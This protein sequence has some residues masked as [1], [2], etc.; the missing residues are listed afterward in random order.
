MKKTGDKTWTVNE[1]NYL[2]ENH[3]KTTAG[4]IAEKLGRSTDSVQSCARRLNLNRIHGK[5]IKE[6]HEVVQKHFASMPI[7]ELAALIGV[8]VA[9]LRLYMIDNGLLPKPPKGFRKTNWMPEH[10]KLLRDLVSRLPIETIAARLNRSYDAVRK[11][12]STLKIGTIPPRK[13]YEWKQGP[14][15]KRVSTVKKEAARPVKPEKVVKQF[16]KRDP[17]MDKIPVKIGPKTVVY[18][19]AGYTP[20]QLQTVKSKYNLL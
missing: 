3:G 5:P 11:R 4:K 18:M 15:P 9:P 16:L 1:K 8:T 2:K 7:E 6:S 12:I 19:Q 13:P 14:P 10:D 17:I 20:Q